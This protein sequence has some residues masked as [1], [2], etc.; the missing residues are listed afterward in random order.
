[1]RNR[2]KRNKG[3]NKIREKWK[4]RKGQRGDENKT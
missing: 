4:N 1:M 3:A 2:V